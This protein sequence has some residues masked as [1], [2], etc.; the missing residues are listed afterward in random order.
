[1]KRLDDKNPSGSKEPT[2]AW[3][4]ETTFAGIWQPG[5]TRRYTVLGV[6]TPQLTLGGEQWDLSETSGG[7]VY[8]IWSFTRTAYMFMSP[9]TDSYILE[10]LKIPKAHMPWAGPMIRAAV[11]FSWAPPKVVI[12]LDAFEDCDHDPVYTYD[13]KPFMGCVNNNDPNQ[14]AHGNV[15]VKDVCS[16]GAVRFVNVNGRHVEEGPWVEK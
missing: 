5:N 11:E 8:I 15:V 12:E 2:F 14:A 3:L 13:P 4:N 16:C 1:M 7:G 9:P 6:N 10:K